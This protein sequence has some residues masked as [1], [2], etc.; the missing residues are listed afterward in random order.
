MNE[1]ILKELEQLPGMVRSATALP[2]PHAV[3]AGMAERRFDHGV[4]IGRGTSKLAGMWLSSV[5]AELSDFRVYHAP[6]SMAT[7]HPGRDLSRVLYFALSE[8]GET[9]DV[10]EAARRGKERGATCYCIVNDDKSEL[11][12][13]TDHGTYLNAY[14]NWGYTFTSYMGT[15]VMALRLAAA[16]GGR[17]VPAGLSKLPDAAARAIA[18][19]PLLELAEIGM[20]MRRAMFLGRGLS[21]PIAANLAMKYRE[22][23]MIEADSKSG[24]EYLHGYGETAEDKGCLHVVLVTDRDFMAGQLKA[25]AHLVHRGARVVVLTTGALVGKIPANL[26]TF[27]V[28]TPDCPFCAPLC[29]SVAF[30]RMLFDLS[31]ARGLDTNDDQIVGKYVSPASFTDSFPELA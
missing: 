29:L 7:R 19:N 15:M 25:A 3:V 21:T 2:L 26:Q 6:L 16:A 13:L 20:G 23:P 14:P 31:N 1:D 9:E 27:A 17:A 10:V 8:S 18:E 22:T 24:E 28:D 5:F 11:M 30:C 4:W 12:R